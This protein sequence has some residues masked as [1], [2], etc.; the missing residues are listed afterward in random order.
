MS[1]YEDA[2][3]ERAVRA[4][5]RT[6]YDALF[7]DVMVGFLFEGKDKE[8]LIEQQLAF[9][10]R[11]LGGPHVYTGKPLP[12]AHAKL[13]LLPGHFARRHHLLEQAL[14]K[15]ELPKHVVEEWLRIDAA[16]QSS[17]LAAGEDARRRARE[18]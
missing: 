17:V 2:G 14:A 13:P 6:L 10:S 4:V 7:D 12:E 3:G 9:T 8:H 18:P 11:F 16:L 1:L 5:L 15:H